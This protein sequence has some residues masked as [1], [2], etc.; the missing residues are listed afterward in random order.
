M[1]RRRARSNPRVVKRAISV[2]AAN[3]ARGRIR[4]PSQTITVTIKIVD[5]EP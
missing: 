3:K 4:A 5:D 2:Y 1:A